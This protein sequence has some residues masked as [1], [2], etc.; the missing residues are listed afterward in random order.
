MATLNSWQRID[1]VLAGMP[2]GN[3]SNGNATISSDPNTRATCTGT[4]GTTS[5]SLGSAILANG[6]VIAIHQSKGTGANQWEINKVSSGGGTTSITL[7]KA[8][9][10]SYASGAQVIKIPMYDTV[11]LGNWTPPVH[12]GSTGGITFIVAKTAISGSGTFSGANCGFAGGATS[13]PTGY[14]G[15]SPTGDGGASTAANGA[16][17]GGGGPN[18]NDRGGGGG[19]GHAAGGSNATGYGIAGSGG[20]TTGSADLVSLS[21]GGAGGGAGCYDGTGGN[22]GNSGHTLVLISKSIN[23]SSATIAL[24]G[25]RGYS[26]V[27]GNSGSGGGGAGGA[28]L[29]VGET[30]N[31]GTSR[32]TVAAGLGGATHSN[33]GGDGSAGG[34]G[35]IAVHYRTS[36]TG[37]AAAGYTGVQDTTLKEG[38]NSNFFN[39]F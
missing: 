35:R 28:L 37:S 5:L 19:G 25:Q 36:V 23:I 16:G 30:V 7:N 12:N 9:Q 22:G 24:D 18:G 10:Y 34:V 21:I 31:I 39:F 33:G 4:A 38:G 15:K 3:G 29:C 6:D 1:R 32:V 2:W 14:Q 20:G 13:N 8:L 26:A 11:T 27:N 17:G